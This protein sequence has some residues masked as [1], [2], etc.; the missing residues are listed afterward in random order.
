MELQQAVGLPGIT[1]VLGPCLDPNAIWPGQGMGLLSTFS[2]R[3]TTALL[4]LKAANALHSTF[5]LYPHLPA[6]GSDLL[7]VVRMCLKQFTHMAGKAQVNF[8]DPDQQRLL[9]FLSGTGRAFHAVTE[10]ASFFPERVV[11]SYGFRLCP[12]GNEQVIQPFVDSLFINP[13]IVDPARLQLVI[14]VANEIVSAQMMITCLDIDAETPTRQYLI[15]T[16]PSVMRQL[17]LV[18]PLYADIFGILQ[19][20]EVA[21]LLD[22]NGP[23]WL[24]GDIPEIIR[25]GAAGDQALEELIKFVTLAMDP[26]LPANLL[27]CWG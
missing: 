6:R 24:E 25:R 17:A 22:E 10:L 11:N 5:P 15:S 18:D 20:A 19:R 9:R 2:R 16:R 23:D 1:Q 14:D 7:P 4:Y 3:R 27:E 21:L 26:S 13:L 8:V 12:Y